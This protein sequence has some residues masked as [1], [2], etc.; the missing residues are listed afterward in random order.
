[1]GHLINTVGFHVGF[2]SNW[3]DI[4]SSSHGVMYAELLHNTLDFRRI[5]SFFFE[6]SI[7]D[8]YS[9]LYSHFTVEGST[10][11]SLLLKMY[12]YDG[13]VEQKVAHLVQHLQNFNKRKLRSHRRMTRRFRKVKSV[14]T[15]RVGFLKL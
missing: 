4:W 11:S 6:N 2:F 9:V 7:T 14:K 12:F 3:P 1:M 8:R 5:M 10:S 13:I 15:L